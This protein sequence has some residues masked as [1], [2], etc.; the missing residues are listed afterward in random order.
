MQSS[1]QAAARRCT[2]SRQQQTRGCRHTHLA[3]GGLHTRPATQ[4][5]RD[6][7]FVC[8]R[9]ALLR[10][11]I[12]VYEAR[13]LAVIVSIYCHVIADFMLLVESCKYKPERLDGAFQNFE[14]IICSEYCNKSS[15]DHRFIVI[16]ST[17]MYLWSRSYRNLSADAPGISP[18]P[19]AICPS[20]AGLVA[21]ARQHTPH[22]HGLEKLRAAGASGA[23]TGVI[24]SA[25]TLLPV[26]HWLTFCR[27]PP[28]WLNVSQPH[29]RRSESTRRT[30]TPQSTPLPCLLPHAR[31]R[32]HAVA[33]RHPVRLARATHRRSR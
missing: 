24:V 18:L 14:C 30:R 2:N 6:R 10:E 3:A 7:R 5:A 22:A 20:F 32:Q 26:V 13:L 19:A 15:A 29:R 8:E 17:I 31:H 23:F 21:V 33:A 28:P 12:S 25:R 9:P 4:Q 27:L 11:K 16:L 1:N